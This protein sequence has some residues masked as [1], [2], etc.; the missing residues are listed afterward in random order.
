M[1]L[2]ALGIRSKLLAAFGFVLATT[3]VASAIGLLSYDRVSESLLLITQKSVPQMDESMSLA[4]LASEVGARVPLIASSDTEADAE[5]EYRQIQNLLEQSK[6]ILEKKLARGDGAERARAELESIDERYLGV[7]GVHQLTRERIKVASR[8]NSLLAELSTLVLEADEAI[9]HS[10]SSASSEFYASAQQ[11]GDANIETIDELLFTD[12][13]PMIN[14]IRI[15]NAVRDLVKHLS[16]TVSGRTDKPVKTNKRKAVRLIKKLG[17]LQRRLD[18][19]FVKAKLE[20]D[21]VSSRLIELASEDSVIFSSSSNPIAQDKQSELLAELSDLEGRMSEALQPTISK[22]FMEA[23]LKG[24]DLDK[25]VKVEFPRLMNDGVAGMMALFELRAEVNTMSSALVQAA[26]A[27]DAK[28]LELVRQR[29]DKAMASAATALSLVMMVSGMDTVSAQ[30]EELKNYGKGDSGIF[31]LRLEEIGTISRISG[32]KEQLMTRQ[33]DTVNSLV[34]GVR[35]SRAQVDDA[36]Q[37]VTSLIKS[38]RY[39]L[40]VVSL[41]SVL[42]TILVYWLLIS[43]H[44][45]TRLMSTINALR[46]LADGQYDVTV[47]CRGFDELSDLARTVEV[48]RSS[49]LEAQQLQVE[50]Q[51]VED[52]LKQQENQQAEADRRIQQEQL[53]RYRIEQSEAKRAQEIA[54]ELQKRVDM[55]LVAVSAAADGDLSHPINVQGDDLAGQMGRALN[56][57]FTELKGSMFSINSS[58]N[59]LAD[60]SKQLNALSVSMRDSASANTQSANDASVL[61]GEVGSGIACVAGATE[62]LSSSITDIARNTTEVETVAKEAVGLANSTNETVSKLAE[63][64]SGIS[65]VIKVITTIAEQTNLLA[66]NAT[67]EAARA[68]EAGKGFAV[69]ANEVKELAKGTA[70]ATEQIEQ[71]IGD[72]QADTDRAVHAI[73]SIS[74]IISRISDIQSGVVVAIGEQTK[75]TQEIGRAVTN[76]SKGSEAISELIDL[77]SNKAVANKHAS[78]DIN[79]SAE[80]LSRT[81]IELQVFVRRFARDGETLQLQHVA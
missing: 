71:R 47:N 48:F 51:Q 40:V 61:A 66:L 55:L 80:E 18:S 81:A 16:H 46:S 9:L 17:S 65:S 33:A 64:S 5:S 44:I 72:I 42:I 6:V 27:T 14:A 20:Y 60:A 35:L 69:V 31:D 53:E 79:H 68:G 21:A 75:V 52:E 62:Q 56:T 39:Q 13:T 59:D 43:K 38:S 22:G 41:L 26:N 29:F 45:L 8:I 37:S 19:E 3:L 23:L 30:F 12:L 28:E 24:K 11:I 32:L 7:S 49:A 67:I 4:Q 73:R 25:H 10:I 57:L 74:E 1:N 50:R 15:D 2:P 63:S 78:D 58:S 36:S 77:M 76:A 70:A 34:E 54:D